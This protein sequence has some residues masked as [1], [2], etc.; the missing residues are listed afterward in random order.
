M[1]Y[2]ERVQHD[3]SVVTKGRTWNKY[4]EFRGSGI[5]RRATFVWT[6]RS[7]VDGGGERVRRSCAR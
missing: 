2:F 6:S 5:L 1:A 4:E 3:V 7:L